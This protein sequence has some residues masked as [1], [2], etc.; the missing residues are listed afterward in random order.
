MKMF[1]NKKKKS[2]S[3][4]NVRCTS[5]TRLGGTSCINALYER[6]SE[7]CVNL[8]VLA[9][10]IKKNTSRNSR[11]TQ[12]RRHYDILG[13]GG[14]GGLYLNSKLISRDRRNCE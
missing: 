7:C 10:K 14:G 8:R 12:Q 9:R 3:H 5:Y 13:R 6:Y 4:E 2:I 11:V 1:Q